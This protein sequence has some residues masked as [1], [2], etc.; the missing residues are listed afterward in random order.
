VGAVPR[1]QQANAPRHAGDDHRLLPSDPAGL[2]ARRG[3]GG[4]GAATLT[5]MRLRRRRDRTRARWLAGAAGA[6]TL[7]LVAAEVAH[8]WRRGHAPTPASARELVRGGEIAARETV[9]VLRAGYRSSSAD[10]TAV[11]NLFL[12]FGLTFAAARAVTHSIRRGFG[13]FGNVRIGRRHI[14]HFVPGIG[15]ALGSG[16]ASI[17]VRREAIDPWLAVPFGAGAALILD[18]T[19]LL[20]ALEDVYWSDQGSLSIEV[21]FGAASL[22]AVLALVVRLVRRGEALVLRDA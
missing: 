22:L 14:H 5:L 18:E 19:A 8:V 6:A 15:L 21:G 20:I 17:A 16:G 7:A 3:D 13:P 9:D 4:A 2:D 11:L 1:V 12:S 10:E